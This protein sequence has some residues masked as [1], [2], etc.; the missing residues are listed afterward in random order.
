MEKE[1]HRRDAFLAAPTDGECVNVA[2]PDDPGGEQVR[3]GGG[4]RRRQGLR[5]RPRPPVEL[6]RLPGDVGQEQD[7]RQRGERSLS[8]GERHV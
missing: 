7:Q 2:G 8:E 4:A 5:R 6:L 1:K 3:P